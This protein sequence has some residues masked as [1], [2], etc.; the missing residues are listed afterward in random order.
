MLSVAPVGP[1][2][3]AIP[4]LRTTHHRPP[5]TGEVWNAWVR[6]EDGAGKD[7]PVLVW[8]A[9]DTHVE[10]LKITSRPP[11]SYL[12]RGYLSLPYPEWCGVLERPSWLKLAI[13]SVPCVDFRSIRG[14]CPGETWARIVDL[15]PITSVRRCGR[16]R[17]ARC[18]GRRHTRSTLRTPR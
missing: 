18:P 15:Q 11:R 10:V 4:A 14:S 7:R 16:S 5:R 8:A 3:P 2:A 1:G 13:L 17:S 9:G 12:L 6:H